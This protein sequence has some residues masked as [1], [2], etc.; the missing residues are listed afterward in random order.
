MRPHLI[1]TA[2]ALTAPILLFV[3]MTIRVGF[4]LERREK[5]QEWRSNLASLQIGLSIFNKESFLGR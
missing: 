2:K 4:L 5:R 3:R 1:D